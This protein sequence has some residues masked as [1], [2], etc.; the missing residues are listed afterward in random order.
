MNTISRHHFA[1]FVDARFGSVAVAPIADH[2]HYNMATDAEPRA[3]E[4]E[5]CPALPSH[6]VDG[7]LEFSRYSL[8]VAWGQAY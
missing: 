6:N 2:G 4:V 5:S 7:T 3:L 8:P 1:Q